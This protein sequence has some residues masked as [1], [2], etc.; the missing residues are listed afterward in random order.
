MTS[1]VKSYAAH[2]AQ[3]PLSLFEISRRNLMSKDVKIDIIYCGVCHSDIHQARNEWWKSNYPLVP[4]HEMVWRVAEVWSEVQKYKVWDLVW[5]WCLVDSCR[6][7]S[8]C[9]QWL[10]TYCLNWFTSTYNGSDKQSGWFTYGW[11]SKQIVV[12]EDFVLSISEDL[13]LKWVA[14]LL[15]A[16]I[17]TYSPLRYRKVWEWHKVG[18]VW[19]GWLWHMAVKFAS[20]FWAEVTILSSSPE[21]EVD[22]KELW[23]DH[24]VLTTQEDNLE[25]LN[26]SFDFIV[27]T[28]S[29]E[30]D[31][32]TYLQMLKID[33]T[34]ICLWAPPTPAQINMFNL[35]FGRRK[36]WGS[37]IGWL[38]ETQEMLD[39]CATHNI[40]SDVE[41]IDMNYINEAY[42]RVLQGDVKY[43]FVI[44]MN[45]L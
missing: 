34:L 32:N 27:D 42:E 20:S 36:I 4:G 38:T 43:R 44:D 5:V 10:E 31:Y 33:W 6:T 16:W 23:A 29:A 7:C 22:A 40:V 11:Y 41:I 24:F 19:L 25:Q 21:K 17:T 8:S 13:T 30:H 3:D 45:T 35:I 2:N 14:P 1:V 12:T 28:V 15:C 18:I 26:K 37:L 39:Y 9:A